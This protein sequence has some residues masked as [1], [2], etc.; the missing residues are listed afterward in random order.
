MMPSVNEAP[1]ESLAFMLR[2]IASAMN[3]PPVL[4]VARRATARGVFRITVHYHDNHAKSSVATLIRAIDPVSTLEVAYLGAF[5]HQP[6]THLVSPARYDGFVLALEKLHF[7][8]MKDQPSIP[9]YG[10]DL[11]LVER[12]AGT[13]HKSIIIAPGRAE[14]RHAALV[15]S[16]RKYLPESLREVN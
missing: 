13:Y 10:V 1:A 4:Q 9:F 8:Q 16:V 7:D 2:G 5:H 11:W 15:E 14:G 12:A 3:L 6:L